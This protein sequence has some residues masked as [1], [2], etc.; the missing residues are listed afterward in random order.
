MRAFVGIEHEDFRSSLGS[1]ISPVLE[2]MAGG[3]GHRRDG[4]VRNAWCY[5]SGRMMC[6][7]NIT[8]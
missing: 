4:G 5:A 6:H 3:S 2:G 7:K 8:R 1:R